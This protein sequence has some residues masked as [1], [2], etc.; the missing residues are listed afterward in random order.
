MEAAL[1]DDGEGGD[2]ILPNGRLVLLLF[3]LGPQ[4]VHVEDLNLHGGV[5]AELTIPGA[6]LQR[7]RL[8]ILT[9]VVFIE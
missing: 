4:V 1:P 7:V 8:G 3:E 6:D 9:H 5:V 2:V